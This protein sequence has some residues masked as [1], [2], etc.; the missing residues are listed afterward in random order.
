[1]NL[2]LSN[3]NTPESVPDMS[4]GLIGCDLGPANFRG[5]SLAAH[6]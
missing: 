1:M 4:L 3:Q 5:R 2:Y 6:E